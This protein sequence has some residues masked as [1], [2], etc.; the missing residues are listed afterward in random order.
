MSNGIYLQE[1]R[2][3]GLIG[4]GPP[5][6]T[7]PPV[8]I[9]GHTMPCTRITAACDAYRRQLAELTAAG[10]ISKSKTYGV[11]KVIC[12]N[13][14]VKASAVCMRISRDRQREDATA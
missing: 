8:S 3:K 12:L 9:R 14:G 7:V 5:L 1:L 2:H 10:R 4:L 6:E 13:Y 11:L